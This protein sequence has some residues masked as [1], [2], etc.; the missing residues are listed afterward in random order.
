M[1]R[2]VMQWDFATELRVCRIRR[3]IRQSDVAK[4]LGVDPAQLSRYEWGEAFPDEARLRRWA[5][6]LE[7]EVPTDLVMQRRVLEPCGTTAAA[8]RHYAAGEKPCEA[9]RQANREY[10]RSRR[11][12]RRASAS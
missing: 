2:G 6:I 3:G 4:H 11:A 9:C 8:A 1:T 7:V 12:S 10:Q 5:A